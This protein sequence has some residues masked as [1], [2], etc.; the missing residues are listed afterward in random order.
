MSLF[1]S[2]R[3]DQESVI[4]TFDAEVLGAFF[5]LFH[6]N[7]AQVI[8]WNNRHVRNGNLLDVYDAT[9]DLWR[10][11]KVEMGGGESNIISLCGYARVHD[12]ALP[13]HSSRLRPY[14]WISRVPVYKAP[15]LSHV[16]SCVPIDASKKITVLIQSAGGREK[17]PPPKSSPPPLA[18]HYLVTETANIKRY[19]IYSISDISG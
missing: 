13:G 11:G 14:R 9:D 7:S 16:S 1:Q 8:G 5:K 19:T 6:D 12:I 10:V 17:V 18:V 4:E 15:K 3:D 2:Y